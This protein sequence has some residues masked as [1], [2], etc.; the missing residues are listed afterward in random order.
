MNSPVSVNYR[1]AFTTKPGMTEKQITLVQKSWKVFRS[2]DPGLVGDVF[3]SRLFMDVPA[4]K[5]LFK[6]PM[7]DQNKKLIDMIGVIVSRLDRLHEVTPDIQEMA[8]R[9]V[10]YGVKPAHYEA[11]GNAL[12]WTL[13]QGLGIDWNPAVKEAWTACYGV[14]ADIMITASE[15]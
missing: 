8:K 15:Y 11:V 1:L 3:Y 10:D 7:A 14:L 13:E 2:I 5:R 12:I 6:A 9:H 4:V